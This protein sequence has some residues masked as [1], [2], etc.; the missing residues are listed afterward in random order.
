MNDALRIGSLWNDLMTALQF[1]TRLPVPAPPYEEGSLAHAVKFFPL[2]GAIVGGGAAAL[3]LIIS[4]HFPIPVTATVVLVYLVCITGCFHEDALA[5]A[6]DAFGG[7][8]NREHVLLIL[9]DSRI[10]SYGGAALSLSLL[11]RFTLLS[12]IASPQ[13]VAVVI[14]A[15][16]LCR[17]T[18]L[19]L[20]FFLPSAHNLE[21]Q[22]GQGSRIAH[23][24]SAGS[25]VVGTLFSFLLA[26]WLLRWR[27]VGPIAS[28]IAITCLSGVYY[29]RRIGGVTGDCFGATNQLAEIAV[30]LCGV[31]TA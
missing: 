6:A 11:A 5:D 30:Y 20:S 13:F 31:W 9:R 28:V 3:Y 14:A 21:S 24:A 26:A 1:L 18:T 10:G 7:G 25:L 22:K 16:T 12:S 15:H 23:L 4:V 8:A 2:V 29:K 17:W 19:P 27:S